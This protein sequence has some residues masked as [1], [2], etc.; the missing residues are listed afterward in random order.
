VR[1]GRAAEASQLLAEVEA[2][3][4]VSPIES[5]RILAGLGEVEPSLDWLE[6]AY[7][8]HDPMLDSIWMDPIWKPLRGNPR[9]LALV[10][11]IFSGVKVTPPPALPN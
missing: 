3:P 4:S 10:S 11:K 7:A 8:A 1:A 5:A 6:K 2:D 9:Y